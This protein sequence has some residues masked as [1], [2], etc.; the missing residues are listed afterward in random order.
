M[1]NKDLLLSDSYREHFV[2][3]TTA[4]RYESGEY[5]PRSYADLLWQIEQQQLRDVVSDMRRT[6]DRIDY[7]DFAAG[8][9]RIISFMESL[10]DSATGIE[11]SPDMVDIARRKLKNARMICADIL[12]PD[13]PIEG[14]YDLITVFRFFLNA[15]PALRRAAMRALA[16]RLKDRNSRLVFNNHG[17][18]WSHKILLWP[19][20]KVAHRG[21]GY[22]PEGNYMSGSEVR[23]LTR[24]A[25]LRIEQVRG[26]GVLSAKLLRLLSFDRALAYEKRL[27]LAP[28]SSAIG[29]NQLYVTRLA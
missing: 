28:A 27:A 10:V 13:A 7:L 17:N 18:L 3:D 21:K 20:H 19:L 16:A 6:H 12:R 26:A 24:Q 23:Q 25:G 29:V 9:G 2:G 8:T 15:E 5:A 11:I 1:I 4:Q 22:R 14:K